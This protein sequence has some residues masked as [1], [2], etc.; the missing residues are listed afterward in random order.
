[1]VKHWIFNYRVTVFFDRLD[2]RYHDKHGSPSRPG[3][4][5]RFY[6]WILN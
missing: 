5:C 1:M 4:I 6:E 2:D 3:L